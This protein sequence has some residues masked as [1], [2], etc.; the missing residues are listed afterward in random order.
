MRDYFDV[1]EGSSLGEILDLDERVLT[2][3]SAA[4]AERPEAALRFVT[5]VLL[6][7]K[8]CSVRSLGPDWLKRRFRRW[9]LYKATRKFRLSRAARAN[10]RAAL[11]QDPSRVIRDL[12]LQRPDLQ[13]EFPL[14]L[15]PVGQKRFVEWLCNFG[16]QEAGLTDEQ[17]IWFLY[18]TAT[19][20]GAGV[21]ETYLLKPEWQQRFPGALGNRTQERRFLCWLRGEFPDWP[22]LR[23]VKRIRGVALGQKRAF[24]WPRLLNR[25]RLGSAGPGVNMLA[26]FC[27]P[28]GLQRAALSARAALEC[29]SV[30]TSCRDVP[31]GVQT[32]LEDR[33]PWLGL[34]IYP[35]TLIMVAPIPH[36]ERVYAQAG[37]ARRDGVYRIATWYWEL[38]AIPEEW[39]RLAASVNEMW[40]PTKFIADTMRSRLTIPVYDMLPAVSLGPV[41]RVPRARIGIGDD[42]YVF[43]FMFDMCSQFERK[44]PIAIIR[45][46]R[47]AF[48]P[49]EK[50]A[51]V[52]KVTRGD[53]DPA[54]LAILREATRSAG[55]TIIEELVSR[56]E[57]LGYIEMCDCFISLHRSEGF[58]LPLA[59]A[60]LLGKPAIATNYS[61]NLSFMTPENSWLVD[62]KL[63]EITGGG[64]I[65]TQGNR[66]A[67]PSEEHAAKLIRDLFERR[68]EA[69]AKARRAQSELRMKLSLQ[70]AGDR[71]ARRLKEVTVSTTKPQLTPSAA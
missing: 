31:S 32:K 37:L 30:Q 64:P 27:Y 71:M 58:G 52:I 51:L 26:H 49:K 2:E 55:V 33:A 38:D 42:H 48:S 62:Y 60:M 50:V 14:A 53:A 39:A 56:S 22:P 1:L 15:L 12:Y 20:L 69:A 41:E 13:M 7:H 65:Y 9:L 10:V 17:I 63:K 11:E 16:R 36:F 21:G 44:N 67:D 40:A 45:A 54:S 19:N 68:E 34:E 59:E 24:A 6:N 43:F 4:D 3:W 47:L 8:R 70:A 5:G 23:E 61:G 28:S 25:K 57:A 29:V 46:F 35:V 66:W 18:D